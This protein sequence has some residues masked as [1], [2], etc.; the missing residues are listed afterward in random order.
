MEKRKTKRKQKDARATTPLLSWK[1]VLVIFG[2]MY[3]L[4]VG[5]AF[6]LAAFLDQIP[7]FQHTD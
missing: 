1:A 6:I 4:I 5:Q 7:R 3:F 2:I